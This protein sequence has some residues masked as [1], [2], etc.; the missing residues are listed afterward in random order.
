[1]VS[2]Q[3]ILHYR[4][5]TLV[6]LALFICLNLST[7]SFYYPTDSNPTK[8]TNSKTWYQDEVFQNLLN[9][10]TNSTESAQ[11]SARLLVNGIN[12]FP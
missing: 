10:Q 3:T 11:N 8:G 7:C 9:K 5:M 4:Y 6:Y 12:S 1:M 2:K